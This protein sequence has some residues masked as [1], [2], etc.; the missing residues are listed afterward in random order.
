MGTYNNGQRHGFGTYYFLDGRKNI[1]EFK[2]GK[3]WNVKHYNSY[4]EY[5]GQWVNGV[6]QN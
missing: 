6:W 5:A 3:E 1:G 4:G 2:N